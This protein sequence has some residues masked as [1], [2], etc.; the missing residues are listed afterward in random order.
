MEVVRQSRAGLIFRNGASDKVNEALEVEAVCSSTS[1]TTRKRLY[2]STGTYHKEGDGEKQVRKDR[3][4]NKVARTVADVKRVE[5]S[6]ACGFSDDKEYHGQG[7][8]L[9]RNHGTGTPTRTF[10]K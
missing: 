3:N 1:D 6:A 2:S 10:L 5:I 4:S 8:E 7:G 9:P